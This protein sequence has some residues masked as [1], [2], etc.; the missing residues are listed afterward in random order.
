MRLVLF[1]LAAGDDDRGSAENQDS[2]DDVEDRG[3]DAAI[4]IFY[5]NIT[6]G[7]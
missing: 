1:G 5:E 3:T 2:A 6:K 7:N 4:V